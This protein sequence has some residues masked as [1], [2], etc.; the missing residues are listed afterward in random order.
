ML[1]DESKFGDWSIWLELLT[2]CWE[3]SVGIGKVQIIFVAES[4]DKDAANVSTGDP[5][6]ELDA[7]DSS[8]KS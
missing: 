8:D 1:E 2:V 3:N 4:T 7:W 5:K 6:Y